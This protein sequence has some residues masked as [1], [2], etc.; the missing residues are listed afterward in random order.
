MHYNPKPLGELEQ[1][2]MNVV[3]RQ[4]SAT[5]RD[6][7]VLLQEKRGIAYT[8]V[9]T[10]MDRL[11]KKGILQRHKIGKAYSYQAAQTESELSHATTHAIFDMVLNQYGDLAIAQFIDTVERFDPEK[12]TALKRLVEDYD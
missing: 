5:V 6:V 7:H 8:T 12:F 11:T 4:A 9:M 1:L 3:W 10:T 2:I